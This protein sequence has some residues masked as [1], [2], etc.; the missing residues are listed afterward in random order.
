MASKVLK[1]QIMVSNLSPIC[2]CIQM[3]RIEVKGALH[4]NIICQSSLQFMHSSITKSDKLSLHLTLNSKHTKT[5]SD[6][7]CSSLISIF[8]SMQ[9]IIFSSSFSK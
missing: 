5:K 7:N 1:Q 9:Y 2:T 3:H 6:R 4:V 8:D